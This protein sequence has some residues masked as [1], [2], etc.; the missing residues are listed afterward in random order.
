MLL[1]PSSAFLLEFDRVP[2]AS[3]NATHFE[4]ETMT[5][6]VLPVQDGFHFFD[7]S[8][9]EIFHRIPQAWSL[10]FLLVGSVDFCQFTK[11]KLKDAEGIRISVVDTLILHDLTRPPWRH[12]RVRTLSPRAAASTTVGWIFWAVS[13]CLAPW[14]EVT[15]PWRPFTDAGPGKGLDR[16]CM[17]VVKML[18]VVKVA[19]QIEKGIHDGTEALPCIEWAVT[20]RSWISMISDTSPNID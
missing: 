14:S 15:R 12:Q 11:F 4:K 20:S 19:I 9:P 6:G 3:L 10:R 13:W 8:N 2:R 1:L 17:K 5:L 16:A 18:K 7:P